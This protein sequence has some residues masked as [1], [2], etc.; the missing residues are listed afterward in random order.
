M[1]TEQKESKKP[2]QI[3]DE[4]VAKNI[5][6]DLECARALISLI[7]NNPAILEQVID[8]VIRETRDVSPLIDAMQRAKENKDAD[9]KLD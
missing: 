4:Q 3:S 9:S 7:L 1:T 5:K 6:M 8:I 2:L